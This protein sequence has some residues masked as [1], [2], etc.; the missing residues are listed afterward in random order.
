MYT[1]SLALKVPSP[2]P[3]KVRSLSHYIPSEGLHHQPAAQD[4]ISGAQTHNSDSLGIVIIL[5]RFTW[6]HLQVEYSNDAFAAENIGDS[7]SCIYHVAT[8]QEPH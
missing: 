2:I 3:P 6:S 8:C 4:M 5:G 1:F 7:I